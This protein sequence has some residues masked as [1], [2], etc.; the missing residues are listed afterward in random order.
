MH[1][2]NNGRD[3]DLRQLSP[4]CRHDGLPLH[5]LPPPPPLIVPV[6]IGNGC[7]KYRTYRTSR[8][9]PERLPSQSGIRIT[10]TIP[11][12]PPHTPLVDH[13]D[14]LWWEQ[15]CAT[16]LLPPL[17]PACC[18][19][20]TEVRVSWSHSMIRSGSCIAYGDPEVLGHGTVGSKMRSKMRENTDQK[21]RI[22]R[23]S[24]I[25]GIIIRTPTSFRTIQGVFALG[26]SANSGSTGSSGKTR[27][28]HSSSRTRTS[29]DGRQRQG[30]LR[31]ENDQKKVHI[32]SALFVSMGECYV[33]VLSR[34]EGPSEAEARV[35]VDRR[36]GMVR[37]TIDERAKN[38][39]L[40]P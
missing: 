35:T 6:R 11:A 32:G 36:P 8:L 12:E 25:G 17:N 30:I 28:L 19:A 22:R 16:P 39:Q 2:H 15:T 31:S 37:T 24:V 13:E 33:Y 27:L 40:R 5:S 26:Y 21:R 14:A 20:L 3:T 9:R 7:Q 10:A 1:F 38:E 34:S 4:L 18:Q 29:K 23:P